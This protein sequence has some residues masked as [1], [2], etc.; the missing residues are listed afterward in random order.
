MRQSRA[1]AKISRSMGPDMGITPSF[2]DNPA[3]LKHNVNGKSSDAL[4]AKN[5]AV[6]TK[7]LQEVTNQLQRD[8]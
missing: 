3:A 6:M 2:C 5:L 8:M 1:L 7:V 4:G